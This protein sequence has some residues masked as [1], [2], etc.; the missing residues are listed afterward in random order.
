MER[1][2]TEGLPTSKAITRNFVWMSTLFSINHGA[3]TAVL[4]LSVVLLGKNG[5]YMSGALYVT[6][7][8]TALVAASAIVGTL[9]NRV[10]LI[11]GSSLYCV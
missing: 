10:A 11:C 7:A 5:S 2:L 8:A 9:G 3:V 6:Y 4:N 1:L